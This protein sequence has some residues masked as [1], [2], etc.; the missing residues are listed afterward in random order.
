MANK[1]YQITI[2]RLSNGCDFSMRLFAKDQETACVA[3]RDRARFS[4]GM[5]KMD[6][7]N[8]E[9][10]QGIAVFRVVSCEVS[11]DQSRPIG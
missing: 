8:L 10:V 2:R 4:C 5:R 7:H 6:L 11:P 3:A 1:A 9:I